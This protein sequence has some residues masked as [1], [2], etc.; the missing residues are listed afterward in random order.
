M[1]YDLNLIDDLCKEIGLPSEYRSANKIAITLAAGVVLLVENS[2]NEADCLITFD[3]NDKWHTHDEFLFYANGKQIERTYFDVIA[4]IPS[5]EILVAEL[6]NNG[7]LEDRWLVHKDF[8]DEFQNMEK[9]DEIRI[10]RM[11]SQNTK[12]I[13][14]YA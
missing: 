9:G 7:Q 4:G 14:G 2:A 5:G 1:Q 6:W 3:G 8:V 13:Q 10:R 11:P 12:S